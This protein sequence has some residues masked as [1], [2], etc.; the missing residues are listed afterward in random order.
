MGTKFY[1]EYMLGHFLEKVND[2]ITRKKYK[3]IQNK[4]TTFFHESIVYPFVNF[5]INK[6]S[7][8]ISS[9]DFLDILNCRIFLF[10]II[11]EYFLIFFR[12]SSYFEYIIL[13][14]FSILYQVNALQSH[15][16]PILSVN[17]TQLCISLTYF[18]PENIFQ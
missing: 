14:F 12:F 9:K 16:L 15:L 2:N 18:S 6:S 10:N 17:F 3:L 7:I 1:Q 4:T 11:I 5:S 8:E 13:Q